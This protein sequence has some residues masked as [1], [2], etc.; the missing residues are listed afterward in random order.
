MTANISTENLLKYRNFLIF[1]QSN[2]ILFD[3][4]AKG[5]CVFMQTNG[6]RDFEEGDELRVQCT[7]FNRKGVPVMSLVDDD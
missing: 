5:P 6:R 7:R 4:V 1:P 2:E 3:R